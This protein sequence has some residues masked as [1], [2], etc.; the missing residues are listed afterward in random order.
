MAALAVVGLFLS[1]Q[2]A[3]LSY[4]VSIEHRLTRLEAKVS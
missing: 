4:A 2:L 1:L 3:T